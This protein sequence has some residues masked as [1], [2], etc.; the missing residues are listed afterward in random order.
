MIFTWHE[1]RVPTSHLHRRT[2]LRN[3]RPQSV[4][5]R[6]Q[7]T[8]L[9]DRCLPTVNLATNFTGLN[10]GQSGGSTPPD[11]IAAAGPN[12]IVEVINSTIGIYNKTSGKL[13][14]TYPKSLAN[15]FAPAG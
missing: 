11:T 1:G 9:E 13:A 7:L 3:T 15:F 14:A 6:P 8:A 12:E 4:S 5:F 10:F 2:R